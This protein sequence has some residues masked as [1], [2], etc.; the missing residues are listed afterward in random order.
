MEG[1][2]RNHYDVLGIPRDADAAEVRRAWKLLVQV[3]HPDRFTG[4]MHDEA[5]R[6]TARINEAYQALRDSSRRAAYDCCLAADEQD[7]PAAPAPRATAA[8]PRTAVPSAGAAAAAA[9]PAPQTIGAQLQA[10]GADIVTA[11]RRHPRLVGVVAGTWLLVFGGSAVL[12]A[13]AGPSLPSGSASRSAS[14]ASSSVVAGAD[15]VPELEELAE[16]AREDAE[17]ASAEMERLMREDAAAAAAAAA[18]PPPAP[19]AGESAAPRLPRPRARAP[20]VEE[21]AGPNGR[22]ILRVLPTGH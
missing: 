12:H 2:E 11:L 3:W 21:L 8:R 7:A 16:Q 22:R 10:A 18:A 17:T 1:R 9:A 6:H 15:A 20:R 19:R 4:D 5:Q 14:D 13:V